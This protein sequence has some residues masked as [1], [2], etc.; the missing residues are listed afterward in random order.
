MVKID[1]QTGEVIETVDT[2]SVKYQLALSE[3]NQLAVFG[4][5]LEKKEAYLT[6]KEQ[7]EMVDAPFRAKLK[8]LFEK[9]GLKSIKNQYIDVIQKNGYN[10]TSWDSKKLEAFIYQNG[11]DPENFK[12]ST[13]VDSS[14]QLKYKE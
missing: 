5:W 4:E 12:K 1:D 13:W 2:N 7:Y 8:E 6:A 3:L 9:F 14:L 10:K 11:G